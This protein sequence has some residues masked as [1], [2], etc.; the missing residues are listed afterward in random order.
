MK[1]LR[2]LYPKQWENLKISG[3]LKIRIRKKT[4]WGAVC[5]EGFFRCLTCNKGRWISGLSTHISQRKTKGGCR[6]CAGERGMEIMRARGFIG[7]SG[8]DSPS[9]KGGKSVRRDGYI[10]VQV[11]P[12]DKF[13][14]MGA[15]KGGRSEW[16]QVFE[17]RLVM[18]RSLGRP[19]ESK[20]IVH[21]K[22]GNP[23]NNDIENLKLL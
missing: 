10:L 13:Y 4:S 12:S 11:P 16:R 14:C 6:H 23:S 5:L 9:W 20:E 19:L 3:A 21:H 2:A 18:A 7:K 22:D 8:P 17:H 15:A 1:R